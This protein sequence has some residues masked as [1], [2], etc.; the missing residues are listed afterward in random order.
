M[1]A[2]RA[3]RRRIAMCYNA[4]FGGGRRWL[5]EVTS[6]LDRYVD[7]DFYCINRTPSP[8]QFPDGTDIARRSTIRAVRDLPRIPG[9]PGRILNLPASW[10]DFL[11][12]DRAASRLAREIDAKQYDLVFVSVGDYTYAPLIL[13]HLRS[14]TAYYCHEPMRTA[15]EPDVDRPYMRIRSGPTGLARRF[16]RWINSDYAGLR[17]RWDAQA[18]RNASVVIVNSHYTQDYARR[19]YAIDAIV[20]TPGVDVDAFAPGE[21]PR[22]RFVLSGPGAIFRSKGY[23]WAIRSIAAIPAARR[24]ALVIAGNTEFAPERAYLESLARQL[25]VT[26]DIRV[27]IADTELKR[28]LRT[29]SVMLYTPHLEPFGLAAVEAMASGTPVVAVREAGPAETVVDGVTG[30]L[31][32]RDPAQLAE[33]VMRILDDEALRDQMGL[34]AREHC[35]RNWTWDRAVDQLQGLLMEAADTK[36]AS[37]DGARSQRNDGPALSVVRRQS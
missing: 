2:A 15:Y 35:V 32:E 14:T 26:V 11:R 36:S 34:A 17:K 22:E 9:K 10:I 6:R 12:F 1:T 23:D 8:V 5:Y 37:R 16:W 30:F 3:P 25:D 19:A 31:R 18:A 27:G 21:A 7:I 28:L 33:A 29:A 20:N 24:P 4:G 13:R